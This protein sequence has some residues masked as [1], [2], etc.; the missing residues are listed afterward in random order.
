MEPLLAVGTFRTFAI[1]DY[2]SER[3][4]YLYCNKRCWSITWDNDFLYTAEWLGARTL[5]H[6]FDK[7]FQLVRKVVPPKSM[8]VTAPHQM[9]WLDGKIWISN[10]QFDY[11]QLWDGKDEWSIWRPEGVDGYNAQG[12]GNNHYHING[13]WLDPDSDHLFIV[14]HNNQLPSWIQEHEYP[15]L[16]LIK[17]YSPVGGC[18]HNIWRERGEL[19][20]C[21]SKDGH[22]RLLD[23]S[24]LAATGGFPRGVVVAN[25]LRVVGASAAYLG[26]K[27][28]EGMDG[29]IQI[30]NDAWQLQKVFVMRRFGQIYEIR[31]MG[32]PDEAHWVGAGSV[33]FDTRKL[34]WHDLTVACARVDRLSK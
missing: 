22:V 7:S 2:Q 11:F 1:I 8:P 9:I 24:I 30:F 14:A 3:I 18:A 26:N 19:S 25:G 28:R 31:G 16:K 13:C 33:E 34:K 4:A 5:F 20:T 10:T 12:R 29:E 23:G 15:S 21:S 27:A 6:V 32:V 17:R